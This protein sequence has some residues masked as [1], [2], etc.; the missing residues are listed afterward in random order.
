[1][2]LDPETLEKVAKMGNKEAF[3]QKLVAEE[4]EIAPFE[5]ADV[6][7]EVTRIKYV[8]YLRNFECGC[9]IVV[10]V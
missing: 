5:I 6:P 3:K 1:M 2:E 4:E 8:Q 9:Y 7:P 10:L